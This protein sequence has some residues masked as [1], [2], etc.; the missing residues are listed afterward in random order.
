[1]DDEVVNKLLKVKNLGNKGAHEGEEGEYTSHEME[2][3]LEAIK[4]FS[5]EVFYSYFVRN[6]YGGSRNGSWIPVV[7][8][9]LPPIYRVKILEKYY[10]KHSSKFNVNALNKEY[11]MNL[12][13]IIN[14]LSMAYVKNK[15]DIEADSF[16]LECLFKEEINY[17]EYNDMVKN[18]DLLREHFN[19]LNISNDLSDAKENFNTLLLSIRDE[20]RDGFVCLVSAVLNEKQSK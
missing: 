20:E 14:K 3:A 12:K 13:F 16:L 1:M 8:S 6:G 15:M 4:C 19:K 5:L 2:E 10:K 18:L 7:F 9:T 11:E 17:Y